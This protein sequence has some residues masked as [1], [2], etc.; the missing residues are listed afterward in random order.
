MRLAGCASS[1]PSS[2]AA[3][4]DSSTFHA[5]TF[6][7]VFQGNG[8]LFAVADAFESAFGKGHILEVVE[9]LQDGFANV[10]GLGAAGT[11]REFFKAFFDGLRKANGQHKHLAI[12]V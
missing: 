8:E 1:L 3:S 12:Q 7:N 10:V 6:Q 4:A 11:P 9:M 5:I 2:R